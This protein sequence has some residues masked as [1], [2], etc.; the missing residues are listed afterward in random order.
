MASSALEA[1]T[2]FITSRNIREEETFS[3]ASLQIRYPHR[4][5]L[6][7]VLEQMSKDGLIE[8][9]PEG[10]FKLTKTGYV[11]FFGNPPTE[12]DTINAI[13]DEIATRGVKAGKT[14]LWMPL[15]E[16]LELKRFRAADLKPALEKIFSDH[17]LEKAAAP[18][19]F[20]LTEAGFVAL[21]KSH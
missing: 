21:G 17:W 8:N 13:M 12:D 16:R 11:K 10:P 9:A 3:F 18:G 20:R 6:L 1:I 5:E 7:A 15:Q 14:F 4:D 2:N 19:F